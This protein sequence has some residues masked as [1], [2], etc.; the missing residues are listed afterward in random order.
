M[1]AL[2]AS[3]GV[4]VRPAINAK[5]SLRKQHDLQIAGRK[6]CRYGPAGHRP[7]TD[8]ETKQL[9]IGLKASSILELAFQGWQSTTSYAATCGMDATAADFEH[10]VDT[11]R[12]AES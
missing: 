9:P 7:L 10:L 3:F 11:A 6:P 8:G 4:D 5:F 1:L 2:E 12:Q